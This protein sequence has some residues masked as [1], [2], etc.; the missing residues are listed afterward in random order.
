[1]TNNNN[2]KEEIR[3]DLAAPR[4]RGVLAIVGLVAVT[5]LILYVIAS[6]FTAV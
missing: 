3:H 2:E 6:G 4:T 1:M 5:A